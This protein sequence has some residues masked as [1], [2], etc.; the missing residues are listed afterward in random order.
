MGMMV[1]RNMKQRA[2]KK[3]APVIVQ[4]KDNAFNEA[5]TKT[6][7]FRMSTANLR[8]LAKKN[9]IDD[10]DTLTGGVLKKLLIEHFN[11]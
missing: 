8:E 11:L 9:S 3:T 7:I 10:A 6:E 5:L 4:K 1:R 2:A